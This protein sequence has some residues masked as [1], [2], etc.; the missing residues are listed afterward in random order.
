M[1]LHPDR[2]YGTAEDSTKLFAEIQSAYE[3]LSDIQ[4][5]AWYDT[6]REEILHG[7]LTKSG[8]RHEG[9]ITAEDITQMF[10]NFDG[11]LDLSDEPSAFYGAL[12]VFFNRLAEEERNASNW[13]GLA[14]V[15][16]PSFGSA[17]DL[18]DDVVKSFYSTWA[19]FSTRKPFSWKDVFRYSEA[20]DRRVRRVMEKENRR[21]REESIK[22]FNESVRALV[23]FIKKR[24]PRYTLIVQ[25]EAERQ[26]V[27]RDRAA[28]Q[29]AKSRAANEA[30]LVHEPLAQWAQIGG[31]SEQVC[32]ENEEEEESAKLVPEIE[33]VVCQ[34]TFKS[35][36]Q[37]LAHEKSKK[38][39]KAVQHLQRDMKR[40]A[41][42]LGL[43]DVVEEVETVSIPDGRCQIPDGSG[44]RE[45]VKG[46]KSSEHSHLMDLHTDALG[47]LEL[48]TKGM[49]SPE[50]DDEYASRE[51][52]EK[53]IWADGPASSSASD[54]VLSDDYGGSTS[55]D[56]PTHCP[57]SGN[58][59]PP[60]RPKF[61]KAKEKRAKKILQK[62]AMADSGS[63]EVRSL[64]KA[65]TL[66]AN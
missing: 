6:H 44:H 40:E 24:D 56:P 12:R 65:C 35:E 15:H 30:K 34:K 47:D 20:P 51:E 7:P 48:P 38:H 59:A 57:D 11:R 21:L 41:S 16:Y 25:S 54:R 39:S 23:A 3:V 17:H 61:G 1:E 28:A 32:S 31:Q 4:E 60:P 22:E 36:K 13:Q 8:E 29:A 42:A 10:M 37:Y 18:Y 26:K 27:L 63:N 53:R 5:R 64:T 55:V 50:S 33:C 52:I 46:D 43:D 14:P 49:P 45:S 9:V 19:N 66:V 62:A 2:N 58:G